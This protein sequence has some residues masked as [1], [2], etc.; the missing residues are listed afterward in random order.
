MRVLLTGCT[1]FLGKHVLE[2]LLQ[3]ETISEVL[4][5]SRKNFNHP[6]AKVIPIKCDLSDP[7][8]LFYVQGEVDAVIHLAGLYSFEAHYRDCYLNNVLTT[9]ALLQWIEKTHKKAPLLLHASTYAVEHGVWNPETNENGLY[10]LPPKSNPYA[11]TKALSEKMIL[12]SHDRAV[13][14]RLGVLV[15]DSKTGSI[16]KLDGPYYLLRLLDQM[17]KL[18]ASLP[19]LPL[20]GAIK[21]ILPLVPVDYAARVF[22]EALF[23]ENLKPIYGVYN[24]SSL[25]VSQ[26]A[27][28]L[29]HRYFPNTK[30][31]LTHL[32]GIVLALQKE[33]TRIPPHLFDFCFRPIELRNANFT[34]D[35]SDC[36]IPSFTLYQEA[37]FKGFE[38]YLKEKK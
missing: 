37:F 22:V 10:G 9:N 23:K 35:F 32:P 5:F 7:T 1:G 13:A 21:A 2:Q 27:N 31:V 11:H 8:G 26:I 29:V 19:V 34:Q 6:D 17:K 36:L 24:P 14:F 16:E 12:S 3:R 30:V 15:G 20:P 33:L 18:R 28:L 38:T 4:V 25:R